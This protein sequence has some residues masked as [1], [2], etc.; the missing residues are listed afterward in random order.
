M[1]ECEA[2]CQRLVIMVNGEFKCLGS[3]QYLKSKYGNGFKLK[4]RLNNENHL[5]KLY[6]FMKENFPASNV[7]EKHKNL[8]EFTLPF[9]YTKLSK[10][11]GLVENNRDNLSIKDY[12]VGQTTLDQVFVDFAKLQDDDAQPLEFS[13]ECTSESQGKK[14][15]K[16]N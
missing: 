4:L 5:D 8:I 1:E 9:Q 2:L 15:V 16:S 13:N 7:S 6:D 14:T 12:S 3:P 10:I 11:F